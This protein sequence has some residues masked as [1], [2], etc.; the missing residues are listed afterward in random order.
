MVKSSENEWLPGG[1]SRFRPSPTCWIE[2]GR[3]ADTFDSKRRIPAVNAP[4]ATLFGNSIEICLSDGGFGREDDTIEEVE[5]HV[6]PYL[7]PRVPER[8]SEGSF[9]IAVMVSNQLK[10]RT[11]W[12][13]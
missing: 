10:N 12:R 13:T 4:D 5:R 8:P 9:S 1:P 3:V 2:I 7:F 11:A 6:A